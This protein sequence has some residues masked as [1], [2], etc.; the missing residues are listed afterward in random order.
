VPLGKIFF[1]NDLLPGSI[2]K[3]EGE[4]LVIGGEYKVRQ[5]MCTV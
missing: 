5:V 4:Y 3:G 2:M 1:Y